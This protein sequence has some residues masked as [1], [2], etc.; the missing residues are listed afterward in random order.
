MI[1]EIRSQIM[2][3]WKDARRELLPSPQ[4][5]FLRVGVHASVPDEGAATFLC[6]SGSAPQPRFVVKL[7]KQPAFSEGIRAEYR[8]LQKAS[9]LF[10]IVDFV[11]IPAALDLFD[12][13]GCAV[14]VES[15]LQGRSLLP[16]VDA[17]GGVLHRRH[18]TRAMELIVRWLSLPAKTPLARSR[19]LTSAYVKTLVGTYRLR[20]S[21]V[22]E[23]DRFVSRIAEAACDQPLYLLPAHGDFFSG[24]LLCH[25][26]R[27]G[28][29]DWTFLQ[30]RAV[31]LLDYVSFAISLPLVGA[32]PEWFPERYLAPSGALD[33]GPWYAARVRQGAAKICESLGIGS[34]SLVWVWG[35]ALLAGAV[36]DRHGL[37]ARPRVDSAFRRHL[38]ELAALGP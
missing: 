25:R 34:T 2:S 32:G 28:I 6:F 1:P 13:D 14:L 19:P 30:E 7:A 10:G 9:S 27:L 11:A 16:T 4:L 38:V 24:N 37:G 17:R 26:G 5:S 29:C 18:V 23:E 35:L 8:N 33:G 36:M 21:P 31:P 22:Q 12:I 20:F 15:F 3:Q